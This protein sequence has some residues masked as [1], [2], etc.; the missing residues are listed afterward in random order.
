MKQLPVSGMIFVPDH[1]VHRQPLQTPVRMGLDEL[2]HQI[3][4]GRVSYL[5]QHDRQVAGNGIAPETG[6]STVV[7][8]EQ[9]GSARSEALA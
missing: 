6:L 7:F 5:Q 3:N 1:Q 4:V 2:A 9:A 8:D